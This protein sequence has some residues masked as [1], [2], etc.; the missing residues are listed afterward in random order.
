MKTIK[1]LIAHVGIIMVLVTPLAISAQQ[2]VPP[3]GGT[4]SG[5]TQTV[6]ATIGN[7]LK[8]GNTTLMSLIQAILENIV[9]PIAAVGVVLWIIWAGL[10]FVLAQGNPTA[11]AKAKTSLLW[12]L[13]GAGI[14]LGAV[15]ISAVVKS[16]VES[17]VK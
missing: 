16:T 12:S 10:Q 14:L 4:G 8:A 6:N 9:M 13:I 2:G 5:G 7:P 17:L 1:K 11:I 15:G 3:G